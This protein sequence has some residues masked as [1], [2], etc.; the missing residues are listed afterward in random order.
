MPNPGTGGWGAVLLYGDARKEMS[1]GEPNSTNNRMELT[2]ATRAL[3]ALKRPC[4]VE[5]HTD[6]EYV[7]KGITQWMPQWKRNHWKRKGGPI[8]N[9]DLWKALDA[10]A[11][12]HDIQWQWVKGH[13]G[14]PENERCDAL[15]SAAIE[16]IKQGVEP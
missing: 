2:A 13:A 3:E 8:K 14:N 5:L 12:R 7:Q 16:R 11:S 15:A 9:I 1:G 6:S 4:R 10:A